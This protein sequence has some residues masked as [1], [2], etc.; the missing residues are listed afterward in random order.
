LPPNASDEQYERLQMQIEKAAPDVCG[1]AWV[2]KYLSLLFPDKLDDFHNERWQR[3]HLIKLLQT[4][5]S[6]S[7]LYANAG[8]FVR[9]ATE[10]GWPVNH[11]AAACNERNGKPV[12]YWR[13]GT[14]LGAEGEFIWPAMRDGDYA[15]IGWSQI[16]DLSA[17]KGHKDSREKVHE[18]LKATYYDSDARTASRKAG[19]IDNFVNSLKRGDVVI[20]ADGQRVLGIGKVGGE[21]YHDHKDSENAPHRLPVDWLSLDEWEMPTFEG[22]LTTVFEIGK[23]ELNLIEAERRLLGQGDLS[24]EDREV[25]KKSSTLD[26]AGEFD[27]ENDEDARDM[28]FG[29]IALRR[30]QRE[31]RAAL[32][33]AYGGKCAISGCDAIAA[34]EAAHIKPYR[35]KHTNHPQNGLLLRADLHTLFDLGYIQIDPDTCRVILDKRLTGTHYAALEGIKIREPEDLAHSPNKV[36]LRRRSEED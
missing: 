16:G 27:A 7:G 10:F 29:A 15:A 3:F 13:I 23:F 32:L 21:Y 4:P 2:H 8:R 11:F 24:R 34:L 36:A 1:L 30:G 12:R 19:E 14:R 9:L 26:A 35:G 25:K 5:S 18:K 17:L 28:A 6:K 22:K 20:A 31:F 33:E